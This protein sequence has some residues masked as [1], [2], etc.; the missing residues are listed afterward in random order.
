MSEISKAID[1]FLREYADPE[2]RAGGFRKKR[3]RY[4][5]ELGDRVELVLVEAS[6]WNRFDSGTFSVSLAIVIPDLVP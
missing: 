1:A 5:R 3:R 2:L 6:S 4:S